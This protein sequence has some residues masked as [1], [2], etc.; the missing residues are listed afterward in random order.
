M[1]RSLVLALLAACS[2]PS[3][4]AVRPFQY[5]L[6]AGPQ[7]PANEPA[8]PVAAAVAPRPPPVDP[9]RGTAID[10]AAA[11][12]SHA[13][14]SRHAPSTLPDSLTRTIDPAPVTVEAGKQAAAAIVLTNTAA[15]ELELYLDDA[16]DLLTEVESVLEDAQGNRV[17]LDGNGCGTGRGC[18][19]KSLAI[20]LA[21]G[22]TARLPF[23]VDGRIE[24]FGGD[25]EPS[26]SGAVR[27]G[28]YSLIAY[29]VLGDVHGAA[30]VR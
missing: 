20:V 1:S 25:C 5:E 16:C 30:V 3:A 7:M 6:P 18:G 13:C 10:L 26:R 28:S 27:P 2:G 24:R 8:A 19:A 22:G 15:T 4:P 14:D 29:T 17:D 9:C 12:A 11:A 21:P 23:Q